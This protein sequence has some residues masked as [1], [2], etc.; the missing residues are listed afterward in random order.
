MF[1][2]TRQA[3]VPSQAATI[4]LLRERAAA[5]EVEV[6]FLRRHKRASFMSSAF[7]FPGGKAEPEDGDDRETTAI[8]ELFEEA[9][10]LLVEERVDHDVRLAW[11]KR[12][13]AGE[14]FGTMLREAQLTPARD[15]LHWWA[16]WITPSVEPKRFDAHF[17]LAEAPPDQEPAFDQTETVD[18]AWLTPAEA[19]A[20]HEA[21]GFPLP[22]P[23]LR[24]MTELLPLARRGIAACVS[25]AHAR[26]QHPHPIM[27]RFAQLG[28]VMALLLPWDTEYESAGVGEGIG[29]PPG[30]FLSTVTPGTRFVLEGMT[31]R[32]R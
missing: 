18:Q 31:W 9:G 12:L 2:P 22:P 26:K 19:I 21:G 24:T 30:H 10:V 23:Q 20:R 25:A 15:R 32:L 16:R 28:D 7:V 14:T 17:F 13:A 29:T 27:P 4:V 5:G 6:F 1:D 3:T 11:R 8:R